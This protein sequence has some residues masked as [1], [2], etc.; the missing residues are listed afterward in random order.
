MKFKYTLLVVCLV[1]AL[2]AL[3]YG[4]LIDAGAQKANATCPTPQLNLGLA[5]NATYFYNLLNAPGLMQQAIRLGFDRWN[6]VLAANPCVN[7]TFLESTRNPPSTSEIRINAQNPIV[8]LPGENAAQL[9]TAAAVTRFTPVAGRPT[10]IR[11]TYNFPDGH[12]SASPANI[13]S[14][15]SGSIKATVHEVGHMVCMADQTTPNTSGG[16]V[17]NSF[18]GTNDNGNRVADRP[19][20]CDLGRIAICYPCPTPTPTPPPPPPTCPRT[21]NPP[22]ESGC[23]HAEDHCLYPGTG[24][25][26]DL[27]PDGTG[28]CCGDTPIVLDI[29]GNGFNLTDAAN[30]V[31]F[32]LNSDGKAEH[33]SWTSVGSD[34]AWLALDRNGNGT[35]DNG[36][37]LFGNYTPQPA[38]PS[39]IFRNGFNALAVFDKPEN[40]G[41]GDGKIDD[42]DSIF[43]QL[44][45]W[46]DRNH[47]GISELD[48]I[49]TLPGLGLA[50]IDL[51]Y[52]ESRRR[53]EH[54][55]RFR[56]RARIRDH[57]GAQ[58]GRWAWDVFLVKRR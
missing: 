23:A 12:I 47:N 29:N 6:A 7:I 17:M 45:L 49:Q 53:D 8:P 26:S 13:G 43:Y 51:D 42:D 36:Q 4:G 18:L 2:L 1:L 19:T 11:V 22:P 58:L 41:N 35:F 34:D 37:E 38:P 31:D 14:F 10:N 25:P 21:C 28:C 50:S 55:N 54:G 46:Q 16:S 44:R 33:L 9:A 52:R 57:R 48:E 56:Y 15:E 40:G 5:P 30:G 39:G 20:S 32:D 27:E 3:K 24:C